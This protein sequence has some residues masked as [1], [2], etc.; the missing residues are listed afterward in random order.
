VKDRRPPCEARDIQGKYREKRGRPTKNLH[1]TG[2]GPG[3]TVLLVLNL[4]DFLEIPAK[5]REEGRGTVT[6]ADTSTDGEPKGNIA[7]GN[8]WRGRNGGG[9]RPLSNKSGIDKIG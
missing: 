8:G 5:E 6:K 7:S 2:G 1:G 4:E 3:S 9:E